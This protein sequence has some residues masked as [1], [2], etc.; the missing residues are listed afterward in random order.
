L[1]ITFPLLS[2]S[3]I[4]IDNPK[5]IA[6]LIIPPYEIKT[7]SFIYNYSLDFLEHILNK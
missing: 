1:K 5:A 6:P 7:S 3:S 2:L 4:L